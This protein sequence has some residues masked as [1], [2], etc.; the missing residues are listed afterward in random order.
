MKFQEDEYFLKN[1]EH[2]IKL[3]G[4]GGFGRVYRVS[5]KGSKPKELALKI[6]ETDDKE[7]LNEAIKEIINMSQIKNH[8]NLLSYENYYIS[9]SLEKNQPHRLF[10]EME[11]ADKNL[12]EFIKSQGKLCERTFLKYFKQILY[13]ILYAHKHKMAH[14]DIKP[15]NVLIFNNNCKVSDWGGSYQLKSEKYTSLK[16]ASITVSH[17]FAAPEIENL[18][19]IEQ[20]DIKN[21]DYYACDIFSLGILGFRCLGISHKQLKKIPINNERSQSE[22]ISAI[23]DSLIKNISN[24]LLTLLKNMVQFSPKKRPCIESIIN[25]IEKFDFSKKHFMVLIGPTQSGKD[26]LIYNLDTKTKPLLKIGNGFWSETENFEILEFEN[27][28]VIPE[29]K[30]FVLNTVGFLNTQGYFEDDEIACNLLSIC[31]K[32]GAN[33]CGGVSSFLFVQA[34]PNPFVVEMSIRYIMMAFGEEAMKS[35]ILL[36]TKSNLICDE[37]ELEYKFDSLRKLASKYHIA[38]IFDFRGRYFVKKKNEKEPIIKFAGKSEEQVNLNVISL[39]KIIQKLPFF[40]FKSILD[41]VAI[42]ADLIRE[43]TKCKKLIETK[44]KK[45]ESKWYNFWQTPSN[46]KEYEFFYTKSSEEARDDAIQQIVTKK[47]INR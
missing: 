3:I 29:Q 10:I 14:L 21:F 20:E 19:E 18:D 38:N 24:E 22:E 33:I 7:T 28:E 9:P 26:T 6:V 40:S 12:E 31:L 30:G 47:I 45:T 15:Q 13:G 5:K 37:D 42:K 32:G 35:S 43:N 11:L 23:I 27:S 39:G 36:V 17:G 44:C 1:Y 2:N 8:E 4:K 41:E 25:I 46:N 34:L 16:L